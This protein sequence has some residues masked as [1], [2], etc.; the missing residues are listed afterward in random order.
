MVW[1]SLC[2][3][4]NLKIMGTKMDN[5]KIYGNEKLPVYTGGLHPDCNY[6]HGKIPYAK[7]VHLYQVTRA[8]RNYPELDDG[9]GHTYK[10]APDLTWYHGKFYVQY[11]T[12][13]QDEHESPG[14][15]ILSSSVDGC[16][17]ENFQVSFP[18]YLIPACEVTDYKGNHQVFD[19]TTYAFMHQ[20]MS[21]FHASNDVM[22]VLG[23]YGW[24]PAL[25]ITNWDNYGIGR[26]VRR[27]YPDGSLGD[28]YFIKINWQGGWKKEDLQ[29]PLYKEAID[30]DMIEACEE[31]LANSLYVQQWAEEHGDKDSAIKVKHPQKGTYQAFCWYHRSENEVIG[32]WK[33]SFV[34]RSTDGGNSWEL[35]VKSPSLVMSGQKIWGC[36]VAE[37]SYALIYDPTLETQ[38]RYPMCM[39]TSEDGLHFADMKLV[40]GEV[41][42]I[43]YK[44]FCKDLGPQYMRGICEGMEKPD[45]DIHLTYSVNKEDIWF[46]RIP[47]KKMIENN[48]TELCFT[49]ETLAEWNLYQPCWSDIRAV[50]GALR[51]TNKEPYDYA[52]AVRLFSASKKCSIR[53]T[54]SVDS[55][56]DGGCIQ[57]ELCNQTHQ[58]A[59]RLIFRPGGYINH[60]T[61]CELGI[62]RWEYR[63]PIEV[64]IEADCSTFSYRVCLDGRPVTDRE[65][66][67]LTFPFMAAVNE[68]CEFSLRTGSPRYL[69]DTETNPDNKP[70]EP[71]TECEL[72]TQSVA[73]RLYNLSVF[74]E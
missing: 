28:I 36:K 56:K 31:L 42:P 61:V 39:V 46:A 48:V 5:N 21:F 10:H 71:L 52:R 11:L 18:K 67:V 60:R 53:F 20:R 23:F 37:D 9:T 33:H 63:K 73:L 27:L 35:P 29:F 50:D 68:L 19:G 16:Q 55:M 3:A 69:A 1:R 40:H 74:G 58:T 26:A 41:P 72:P 2:V 34:S 15:S 70:E 43:R 64:L 22:L 13:P 4:A 62:G 45:Q 8:N 66:V 38:H 32:L 51:I 6:F 59:I 14:I 44:G 7:G 12:S 49:K 65:G 54:I 24:S 17:W 30:S 25:W 57:A 47:V